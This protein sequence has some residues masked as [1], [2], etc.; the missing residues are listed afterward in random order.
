MIFVDLNADSVVILVQ[1]APSGVFQPQET[2]LEHP[3]PFFYICHFKMYFW[4]AKL[5]V[6]CVGRIEMDHN[7]ALAVPLP[8][9]S[10]MY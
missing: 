3:M 5:D 1:L 6:F 9:K 2:V 10:E 8:S 7:I 4:M